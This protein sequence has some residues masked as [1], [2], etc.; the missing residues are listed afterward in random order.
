MSGPQLDEAIYARWFAWAKDTLGRDLEAVHAAAEAACDNEQAGRLRDACEAAARSAGAFPKFTD[1]RTIALAEWAYWAHG[2]RRLDE[3]G[4]L[5]AARQALAIVD[6][7]HNLDAAVASVESPPATPAPAPQPSSAAAPAGGFWR[8]N[9]GAVAALMVASA[10]LAAGATAGILSALGTTRPTTVNAPA[11]SMSVAV[12]FDGRAVVTLANFPPDQIY[13]V[14][15]DGASVATVHTD[16]SGLGTTTIEFPLGGHVVN[17][18]I[19][20]T[21]DTCLASAFGTRATT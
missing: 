17:A 12:E 5:R 4:A 19:E 10:I 21:G 9:W 20:P 11:P 6:S 18:C 1:A 7:T 8:R 3:A 2:E 13:Y 15:L 16:A 14:L